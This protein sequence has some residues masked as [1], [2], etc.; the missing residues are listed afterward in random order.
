MLKKPNMHGVRM[1]YWHIDCI[2]VLLVI[3]GFSLVVA[4]LIFAPHIELILIL[5][6]VGVGFLLLMIAIALSWHPEERIH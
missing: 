4:G 1:G 6:Y 3:L 5:V 2:I